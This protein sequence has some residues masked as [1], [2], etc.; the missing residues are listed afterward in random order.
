MLKATAAHPMEPAFLSV[1]FRLALKGLG[2]YT[3]KGGPS[4]VSLQQT[5][6][7]WGELIHLPGDPSGMNEFVQSTSTSHLSLL[8]WIFLENMS[9]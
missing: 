9:G 8:R 5:S 4:R 7:N 1:F 3:E 6:K 2:Y